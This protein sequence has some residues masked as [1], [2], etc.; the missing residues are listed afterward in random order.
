[1]KK[2]ITR[3]NLLLFILVLGS[4]LSIFGQS[5]LKT[6]TEKDYGKWETLGFRTVLSNDG[7]WV[8][9]TVSN[10]DKDTELR[11]H[12]LSKNTSKVI[13]NG[14]SQVFSDDNK[15]LGYL[16]SPD[17]K[18]IEALT[19]DKKPI[20]RKFELLNLATG[21]TTK[22]ENISTFAFSKDGKF[23]ALKPNPDPKSESK[24]ST[25]IVRNL[26]TGTD[27][28]FGNVKDFAW[29]DQGSLLAF[30]VET[31]EVVGNSVML[32]DGKV[33]VVLDSKEAVYNKLTWRR[34]STDLAVFRSQKT[35]GFKDE[36][37]NILVWKSDQQYSGLKI[38]SV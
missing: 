23:L 16:I 6:L 31:K 5:D 32:F 21:E 28:T 25:I 9:Y 36:T 12:D 19:K 1:M 27:S 20:I 17:A 7:N 22:V 10:N 14:G 15:W 38:R 24:T 11:L 4:A 30:L 3:F 35:E 8:V 33:S 26:T 2:H 13:K 34:D 29:S 37:N 18:T